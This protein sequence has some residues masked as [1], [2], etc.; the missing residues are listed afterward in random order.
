M[1]PS[2]PRLR[3]GQAVVHQLHRAAYVLD[4]VNV[5]ARLPHNPPHAA[6]LP[7]VG[8]V[9][10][11]HVAGRGRHALRQVQVVVGD[12]RNVVARLRAVGTGLQV[13]VGIVGIAGRARQLVVGIRGGGRVRN[14]GQ[15]VAGVAVD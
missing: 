3:S 9:C 11:R 6:Q 4:A 5:V 14:R 7:A 2:F 15:P 13:A 12:R 1:R 10:V 8:V